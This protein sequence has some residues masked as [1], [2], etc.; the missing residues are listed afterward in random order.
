[1]LFYFAPSGRRFAEQADLLSGH[2]LVQEHEEVGRLHLQNC[3]A[4]AKQRGG[5]QRHHL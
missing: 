5:Q 1:M 4:A 3:P 2:D